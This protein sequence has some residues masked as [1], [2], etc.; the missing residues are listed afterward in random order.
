MVYRS[1][2]LILRQICMTN[3]T[4][5]ARLQSL[6]IATGVSGTYATARCPRRP[7]SLCSFASYELSTSQRDSVV[8][9]YVDVN[10][11]WAEVTGGTRRLDTVVPSAFVGPHNPISAPRRTDLNLPPPRLAL[12]TFTRPLLD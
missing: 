5:A 1:I 3:F 7:S 2:A 6:L 10:G 11:I 8:L 9:G 12:P 4:S